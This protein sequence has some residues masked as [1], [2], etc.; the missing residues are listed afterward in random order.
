M[1]ARAGLPAVVRGSEALYRRLLGLYPSNH[2]REFGFWMEQ[3]FRDLCRQAY[4]REGGRG[5]AKVWLRTFPDLAQS[6][7]LEHEDEIRRWWMDADRNSQTGANARW[8]LG[9][10]IS[11]VILA[12]GIFTSVFLRESGAPTILALGVVVVFNLA[13]ALVFDLF[14]LRDGAVL[15][16]MGLMMLLSALPLLWVPDQAAWMRENP[17]T[18]GVIIL[19]SAS[20]RYRYRLTWPMYAVALILGAAH[21]L[22]SLI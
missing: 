4:R 13:G 5:L 19:I 15:G 17:L 6:V 10:I 2:R 22:A 9:L 11:A 8:A 12:A 21:I 16:A 18:Y 14:S 3:V 7:I 1:S 20:I